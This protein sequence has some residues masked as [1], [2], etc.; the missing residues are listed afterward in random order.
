MPLPNLAAPGCRRYVG[1]DAALTSAKARMNIREDVSNTDDWA[2]AKFGV[3]QPV[4][5][6]ED[7]TL[8][9]GKGH[10]TDD[11]ALPGQAY[12]VMVRSPYA[13]GVIN[14][15]DTA[16]AATMPGVLGVYTAKDLAGYG[17]FKCIVPFKNTDGTEMRKPQ[18]FALAE[19]KVRFA[20]DPVAFV[21]AETAL[22]A[23]DAAE[24]VVLDIE[25]LPAVTLASEA[26]A[27]DAPQI[28]DEAPGNLALDYHYGDADKVAA[29]FANAAHVTKLSLRNT[30]LVVAA[31]E[32]RAAVAE[33][34]PAAEHFTLHAQSQ[35]AFGIK[36][37]IVDL[38]GVKPDK[39]R[40][41]TPNVGGSFGMKGQAYSEYVCI[42]H[43]ARLLGRPVKWT[44]DRS[45]AFVSDSHGRD[46]EITAE[47]ALDKDGHFLAVRLTGYANMG[48]FL[49]MVAPL[50]GTLNA[51]KN[52]PS[53]Y[54]TPLLEVAVK[55]MFT[56][57]TQVSAYRGAGRPEGNY[58]MERL[59]DNAAAEMG[60]DRLE[61]R[62][63]NHIAP[64]QIPFAASSGMK[65][66]SGDFTALFDEAVAG[67]DLAGFAARKRESEAR[68]KLRGLG[69]GSFLEVTA[70]PGKEMGGIRFED[71]GD[72]TIV[73]GTLD[74]DQGHAAPFAQV[75]SRALGIPF[76]RIRLVQGDSDQL[77]AGGG[78]GGSRSI[79]ASGA[80]ILEASDKVIENGKAIASHVL[81]AAVAD[82]EF[83]NGRFTIAG[84]DRAI[85]IMELADK[86]RAGL[87][88][89]GDTPAKLDA[90]I[91]N[92]GVPS[93][94]PNG[95][96]VAEVEIDPD[97]GEVE[98]VSYFSV[99]D[100]GTIVNPLLV[101]GQVHG[102]V[103]QGIGQALM[104]NAV[105]DEDGQLLTGS[106]QDYAMPRAHAFPDIGFVSHPSPATTNPL[107][108]KGCGEAGCAG[109][110]VCVMNAIVDA[111][112]VYGI[113]HI[114]MP[115][116][117]ARVW[118]A[119]QAA[120]QAKA[121]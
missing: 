71:N 46:H 57:T 36:G 76:E 44:D 47:L 61:L 78:T 115:A 53:V 60:I 13:H 80:A 7:P 106:F 64:S 77:I 37:Q 120:K 108:T 51:V 82:I 93:S 109:A 91:V 23:R 4:P 49:A 14:G 111:L 92:E 45:G 52:T 110:L 48:A 97:T 99:N 74:Y 3:G 39:V 11:I 19:R 30:R 73:T 16:E 89:P 79:T 33:Y 83:A 26:A 50:P 67:A 54:R 27:P 90:S 38:M 21:V 101:Q 69:I 88:L 112:S 15:I 118:A 32:P 59:I 56:N 81:E 103:I 94:F 66:D 119:I 58:Y 85:G 114:D 105:Y 18:R 117:P 10:Y 98:V 20:G 31:M 8:V 86:L 84:T 107:G 65:Y 116:S 68:G 72:V 1:S 28:Y 42:L 121:A 9:Q 34:D 70:P 87:K 63:R 113:R 25:A 96:H 6:T 100:F 41:V 22:Q 24:A 95:C 12:A 55:C 43:A 2:V 35:G 40:V 102:G 75:L 5:R 29:A 104:E 17:T 62:R